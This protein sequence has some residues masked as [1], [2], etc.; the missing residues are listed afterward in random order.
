MS[1]LR[2]FWRSVFIKTRL[3]IRK[4]LAA[5]LQ[6]PSGE[7]YGCN[8]HNLQHIKTFLSDRYAIPDDM[9]LQVLTHKSFTN[10]LKPYNEK[11][12][13][14]GSKLLNLFSAKFV[15]EG[16]TT[17]ELAVNGKNLDVLGTPI[18]KEL[19]GRMALGLFAKASKLNTIMF[20]KSYNSLL[21]FQESGE[22]K[23]SA[24]MMYALVG[25]VTFIHGKKAAEMFVREKLL[26]GPNSLENIAAAFLE[27]Q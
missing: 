2:I 7:T 21:S 23:V 8:S 17:N 3:P 4:D 24:Q 6:F 11:L 12:S 19:G 13:A 10:G 27:K 16:A 22:L 5:V 9:A 20:W 14:M 26:D 25:A 15:V 18:A 1:L